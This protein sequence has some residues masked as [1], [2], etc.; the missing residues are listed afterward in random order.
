MSGL[1]LP[2]AIE[3]ASTADEYIIIAV[4]AADAA[5]YKAQNPRAG[6]RWIHPS[7]YAANRSDEWNTYFAFITAKARAHPDGDAAGARCSWLYSQRTTLR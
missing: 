4:D 5:Q 3:A 6:K 7:A 2:G 1:I